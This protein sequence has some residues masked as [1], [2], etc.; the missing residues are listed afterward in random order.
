MQLLSEEYKRKMLEDKSFAK[1]KEEGKKPKPEDLPFQRETRND[2]A[3]S[4]LL[5]ISSPRFDDG[6]SAFQLADKSHSVQ[7]FTNDSLPFSATEGNLLDFHQNGEANEGSKINVVDYNG[8]GRDVVDGHSLSVDNEELVEESSKLTVI[9][10]DKSSAVSGRSSRNSRRQLDGGREQSLRKE[11]SHASAKNFVE[12]GK[13]FIRKYRTKAKS[14]KE[15]CAQEK[16]EASLK[17]IRDKEESKEKPNE[18]NAT[19]EQKLHNNLTDGSKTINI[20]SRGTGECSTMFTMDQVGKGS[21]KKQIKKLDPAF[22]AQMARDCKDTEKL[23]LSTAGVLFAGDYSSG[24]ITDKGS[25]F[26][27]FSTYKPT[28][29]TGFS[30]NIKQVTGNSSNTMKRLEDSNECSGILR[31]RK[32]EVTV[33]NK[34]AETEN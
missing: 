9:H 6:N 12:E 29:P 7:D 25:M 14:F 5:N 22:F 28:F 20:P 11:G 18:A 32:K 19:E 33:P 31:L 21:S 34:L 10:E 26:Q 15:K 2:V 23:S 27:S 13:V 16:S 4:D 1:S 30:S 24:Y 8:S 17:S 3:V